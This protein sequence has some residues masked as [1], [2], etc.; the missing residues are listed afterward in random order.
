MILLRSIKRLRKMSS[1]MC[2]YNN[3]NNIRFIRGFQTKQFDR[4]SALSFF[5]DGV[6]L[7]NRHIAERRK[8]PEVVRRQ[9]RIR[10]KFKTGRQPL[11]LY[12]TITRVRRHNNYNDIVYEN[13]SKKKKKSKFFSSISRII[14][15]A[16]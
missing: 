4:I 3:N 15:H 10:L 9:S 5:V 11:K 16:C 6:L 13:G 7:R 2:A 8:D 14:L 12:G 1:L